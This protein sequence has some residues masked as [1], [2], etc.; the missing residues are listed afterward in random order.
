MSDSAVR[1]RTDPRI[2][3]RR[4]AV[5]RS[6]KRRTTM[7]ALVAA[8]VALAI[9]VAFFSPLLAIKEITLS[10]AKRTTA[11]DV[12][13]AVGL[14]SSDNLL[15]LKTD[16]V[17]AA[18]KELPWVKSVTVDRKLPGTVKLTVTERSPAMVVALGEKKYLID[19]RGRVLSPTES[20]E[21]LPVLAGLQEGLPDP[22]ERLRSAQLTGALEAFSTFPRGL[23]RDVRAVFAPTVERITF[24]LFDGIQVR[25]GAAEDMRSKI[26]VL[27]VLLE[28]L[29]RE[30]RGA[31]YIDVRVP[32]APAVSALPD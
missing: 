27:E 5:A 29:R 10:G 18:V 17:A 28:R 7:R 3:R 1:T 6:K 11:D 15:L 21:G 23:R 19:R 31:L 2:S 30:G 32:E 20:A 8:G 25:F 12:A 22:G 24:Q 26:A 16:E 14:D 4:R 9:W 13:R